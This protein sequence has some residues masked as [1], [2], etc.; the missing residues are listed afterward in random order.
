MQGQQSR[1]D[2]VAAA[3][4]R[5]DWGRSAPAHGNYAV[6]VIDTFGKLDK[7][8]TVESAQEASLL[9]AKTVPYTNTTL[10]KNR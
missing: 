7:I 9:R 1:D 2:L 8:K 3:A 4:A 10:P 5:D 6:Q